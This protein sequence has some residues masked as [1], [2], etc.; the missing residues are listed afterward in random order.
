ML[1][2]LF[3][4][5]SKVH[6]YDKND[7]FFSRL[8]TCNQKFVDR[9]RFM[10]DVCYAHCAFADTAVYAVLYVVNISRFSTTI[11]LCALPSIRTV[12]ANCSAIPTPFHLHS[13]HCSSLQL[14][15]FAIPSPQFTRPLYSLLCLCDSFSWRQTCSS[16]IPQYH[17]PTL[18]LKKQC[19]S[20]TLF[21][22]SFFLRFLIELNALTKTIR[23]NSSLRDQSLHQQKSSAA[24][25]I[26]A[27]L[28]QHIQVSSQLQP[29][30]S[31]HQCRASHS[32]LL[33]HG[34]PAAFKLEQHR[35]TDDDLRHLAQALHAVPKI[36]KPHK[37]KILLPSVEP[38]PPF[39]AWVPVRTNY[40]VTTPAHAYIP[41]LGDTP[42]LEQKS[43]KAFYLMRDQEKRDSAFDLSSDGEIDDEGLFTPSQSMLDPFAF[44]DDAQFMLEPLQSRVAQRHAVLNIVTK[45]GSHQHVLTALKTALD[46]PQV[47]YV[48]A[49][50]EVARRRDLERKALAQ[51]VDR[52]KRYA[53]DVKKASVYPDRVRTTV[54]QLTFAE[55]PLHHFCFA[56]QTYV[57]DLHDTMRPVPRVAISDESQRAR[58]SDLDTGLAVPCS[59]A[60]FLL[61]AYERIPE[62]FEQDGEWS[63]DD[64]RILREAFLLYRNDPC[65]LSILVGS[66]SCVS[67]HLKLQVFK[68]NTS[69]WVKW[70][71][72]V[73]KG[74][75]A[76]VAWS[77]RLWFVQRKVS[78][79]ESSSE[80]SEGDSTTANRSR[81]NGFTAQKKKKRTTKR[82]SRSSRTARK[83]TAANEGE[84]F[85]DLGNA[86]FIPCNH[87]GACSESNCS[88]HRRARTCTSSCACN[89]MRFAYSISA[90]RIVRKGVEC[91]NTPVGCECVGGICDP[92]TCG[93]YVDNESTCNPDVCPCDSELSVS[94]IGVRERKCK[95]CDILR[96]KRTFMGRSHEEGVGLFAGEHFEKGD[97]IGVYLGAQLPHSIADGV[98]AVGD[99]TERT[100]AFDVRDVTIDGRTLGAKIKFANHGEAPSSRNCKAEDVWVNGHGYLRIRATKAVSPGDEFL[101]NYSLNGKDDPTWLLEKRKALLSTTKV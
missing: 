61:P 27:A 20:T 41:Y 51:G 48:T 24:N 19:E 5:P 9:N 17:P 96:H 55:G 56:C 73:K 62:E 75:D 80:S 70:V 54:P 45:Y 98:N 77:D 87:E 72:D 78:E 37:S 99:V 25:K 38:P 49:V 93:C 28:N 43:L 40:S 92:E 100:F 57:C 50:Y 83:S 36:L 6:R 1:V 7:R 59:S 88:C 94:D 46:M 76:I 2:S 13:T 64:E 68:D 4:S 18:S 10:L 14:T 22:S 21:V 97:L 39:A 60:C 16:R 74:H 34:G 3:Y 15:N 82:T 71:R 31:T 32:Y 11:P 66:K 35:V 86:L 44:F 53:A 95:N 26:R 12:A 58:I 23:S 85:H 91:Q 29:Q 81:S 90:N 42:E 84:D 63:E 30:I 65:N 8:R 79:N 89:G 101:F 47:R 33:L 69:E 52:M 67:V